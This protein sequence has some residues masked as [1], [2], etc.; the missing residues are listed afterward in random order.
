MRAA[1]YECDITPPLGGLMWGHY[2]E[3]RGYDVHD[4]LYAKAVVV[5]DQ[6]EVAAIV[7]VDTCVLPEGI[8]EV[9]TKRIQEFTGIAPERVCITSNHTHSGAPVSSDP[10]I[11]CFADE[12]YKDVFFR[13]CADAV[14]LA[15]KRLDTVEAK[16]GCTEVTGI[17]FNRDFLLTDGTVV[18]HCRGRNNIERSFGETDPALPVLM[19]YQEGKP[20]GAII[21]YACHQCCLGALYKDNPGYSGDYASALSQKLK[22][23]YGN[24]FVSLFVLGTCGDIAHVN[25]DPNVQIPPYWYRKMGEILAEGVIRAMENAQP[26]PSGVGVIAEI[27]EIQR[28]PSDGE[29]V[30][31]LLKK[32][33]E[34]DNTRFLKIRNMVY[35]NAANKKESTALMVQGI[36]IGDVLI[37]ALPGEVFVAIG[38]GIKAGSPFQRNMVVEN[39]NTYCGYIPTEEAFCESSDLYEIT[40]CMHSCHVPEA[41]TILKNKALEIAK[42]LAD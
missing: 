23:R 37:S 10:A 28:R 8:H 24:D 12:T 4:K 31:N 9:V 34:I 1:F 19:F 42:K 40:L 33:V 21:N 27:V 26:V 15:Y 30:M 20:I 5:E 2:E 16:F 29:T 13:L 14:T 3:V 7:V 38:K 22:E 11:G 32:R 39:S 35:Y 36:R 6:G 25:P 41:G 18:T 17:A